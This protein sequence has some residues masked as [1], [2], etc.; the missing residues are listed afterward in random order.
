MLA[1]FHAHEM[2]K[3]TVN[4]FNRLYVFHHRCIRKIVVL[5]LHDHV[6]NKELIKRVRMQQISEI[7]CLQENRPSSISTI[8]APKHNKSKRLTSINRNNTDRDSH[9]QVQHVQSNK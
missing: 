7:V 2:W 6:T 3:T 1:A 8:R 5:S 4:M 9:R